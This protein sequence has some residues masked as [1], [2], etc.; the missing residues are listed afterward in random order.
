MRRCWAFCCSSVLGTPVLSPE[1]FQQRLGLLEVGGIKALGELAIDRRQQVV[2]LGLIALLL[3]QATQACRDPQF[4]RLRLLVASNLEGLAKTGVH[5]L[6]R[7][8]LSQEQL[9]WS[10]CISASQYRPPVLCA[11]ASA[12]ANALSPASVC[13]ACP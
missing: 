7:A 12:S 13:P 8:C 10:R 11:A 5:L 1:L 9:S 4:Q 6:R 3:P 2:G